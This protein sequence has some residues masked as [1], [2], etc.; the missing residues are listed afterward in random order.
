MPSYSYCCR[1]CGANFDDIRSMA[2]SGLDVECPDCGHS[3]KRVVTMPAMVRGDTISWSNENNGKGRRISQLDYGV[4]KP[5]Y[6]K[7]Q[8][9]AID[10]AKKRGLSVCKA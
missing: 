9:A 8:G 3:A 10:E 6:A 5:Y 4:R 2:E 1:K 7:S